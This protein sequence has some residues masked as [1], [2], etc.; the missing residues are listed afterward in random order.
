M[1]L[2][3]VHAVQELIAEI[4]QA[5]GT[6]HLTLIESRSHDCW[7]A[8]FR[9]YR[10]VDWLMNQ[11]HG[12][13]SAPPP[14]E[15]T[16]RFRGVSLGILMGVVIVVGWAIGTR[17]RSIRRNRSTATSLDAESTARTATKKG[18]PGQRPRPP[19]G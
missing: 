6:A 13:D 19:F 11:A 12:S 15:R 4:K 7:T 2:S 18:D 3:S 16:P 17:T 8:A 5:G 1:A 10:I 14:G 9:E